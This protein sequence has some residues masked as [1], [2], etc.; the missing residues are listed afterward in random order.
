NAVKKRAALHSSGV[1]GAAS[2][3]KAASTTRLPAATVSTILSTRFC[4]GSR[5]CWKEPEAPPPSPTNRS[6]ALRP[7]RG[8]THNKRR[9]S[10]KQAG[11]IR[12]RDSPPLNEITLSGVHHLQVGSALDVLTTPPLVSSPL[13]ENEGYLFSALQLSYCPL[14]TTIHGPATQREP[15]RSSITGTPSPA[16][17]VAIQRFVA[18]RTAST[19]AVSALS[20]IS[21]LPVSITCS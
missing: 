11:D 1:G 15:R 19:A 2:A 10:D 8:I 7:A 12:H 3:A 17:S 20:R 16:A 21:A 14:R 9:H 5:K 18:S 6:T 13:Q 4:I